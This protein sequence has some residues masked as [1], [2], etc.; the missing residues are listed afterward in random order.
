MLI[1]GCTSQKIE[2]KSKTIQILDASCTN[3]N[4]TIVVSNEGTDRIKDGELTI[5]IDDVDRTS[6]FPDLDPLDSYETKIDTWNPGPDGVTYS[7]T[8]MIRVTSPSNSQT[9]MIWC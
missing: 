7:G 5:Q 3:N 2:M 4:I 8:V 6:K 1:S 9:E